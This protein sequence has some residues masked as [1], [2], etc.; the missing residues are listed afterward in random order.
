MTCIDLQIALG[1]ATF[2]FQFPIVN[3]KFDLV[4]RGEKQNT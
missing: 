2:F 1:T 3:L 4:E